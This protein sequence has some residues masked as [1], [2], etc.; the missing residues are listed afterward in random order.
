MKTSYDILRDHPVNK[1]RIAEGSGTS[2]QDVNILLKQF[3]QSRE[4]MKQFE[5]KD[6]ERSKIMY[7]CLQASEEVFKNLYIAGIELFGK[8]YERFLE[9]LKEKP[10]VVFLSDD[11]IT[12]YNR[13]RKI[14]KFME[15]ECEKDYE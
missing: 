12:K 8:T 13:A 4:M 3:N 2:I 9:E 7:R 5:G 10:N 11:E 15:E 1:K 6:D 14:M